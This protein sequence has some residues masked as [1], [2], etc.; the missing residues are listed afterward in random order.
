[1]F[2][3]FSAPLG[4]GVDLFFCRIQLDNVWLN[5]NGLKTSNSR[6]FVGGIVPFCLRACRES[7]GLNVSGRPTS[8]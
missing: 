8:S 5:L 4:G 6:I 7:D 2:S 3:R 1:M